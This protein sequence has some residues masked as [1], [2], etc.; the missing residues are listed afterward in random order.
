MSLF[1]DLR[2]A[3]RTFVRNPGFT[4]A[5]VVVLALGIGANTAIFSVVRSVLLEQL[6]VAEPERLCKI[7]ISKPEGRIEAAPVSL[8]DFQEWRRELDS[9]QTL[10]A[11]PAFSFHG[12]TLAGAGP[13]EELNTA[14]VSGGYFEAMGVRPLL[15]RLFT[16]EDDQPPAAARKVALSHAFWRQRFGGDP[17][18]VGRTLRLDG[19]P[20][21]VAAILPPEF[22]LPRPGVQV[23]APLLTISP[24]RIPHHIRD[25]RWLE[26]V[27]RLEPGVTARQAGA[28]LDS[29]LAR[30]ADDF[31]ETNQGWNRS[32]IRPLRA[33]IVQDARRP[34]WALFAAVALVLLIACS[35]VAGLLLARYQQREREM[36]VRATLGAGR[37][38]LLRQ[39]L[40]EGLLLALA[41]GGLGIVL[42]LWC[43]DLLKS[44]PALAIPRAHE[45][46][47]DGSVLLFT[48][49]ASLATLVLFG[50]L[51]AWRS[52]RVDPGSSLRAAPRAGGGA[53]SSRLRSGL[54]V[55][56]MA[57]AV[58]L[59]T[60][61]GLMLHSLWRLSAVEPGFSPERVLA[62]KLTIPTWKY[63]DRA[64]Y[65][66][67]HERFLEAFRSLPGVEA[68][69]AVKTLPF[70]EPP[71]SIE[72]SLPGEGDEPVG[73]RLHPV[74][75]GLLEALDIPLL[76]GRTLTDADG[77]DA[78]VPV[79][80]S[81][82]LAEHFWNRPDVL[83]EQLQA[84]ETPLR[85]VGVAADVH[86]SDLSAE[87]EAAVYL[88]LR[89]SPRRRFAYLLRTPGDPGD[90]A[91]A[92]RQA[93]ARIEP[94][95]PLA[96]LAPLES[97]VEG[98][99][100]RPRALAALLGLFSGLGLLLAAVGLYGL[101]AFLVSRRSYEIGVRMALGACRSDVF[102]LVLGQGARLAAAGLLVGAVASLYFNQRL[103]DLLFG[104]AP[105]DPLSYLSMALVLAAAALAASWFPARRAARISPAR[106]LRGD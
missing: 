26:V 7:W 42:A 96:L 91:G 75:G 50:S 79:V 11:Y 81:R 103:A 20:W 1:S 36:A 77:Y 34:L 39:L 105:A 80:I 17:G 46:G 102:W 97:V 13:A 66:A 47:L 45:I 9:F 99:L 41:A 98:P 100:G 33:E 21:E 55:A 18:L 69:G 57:L 52:S 25:V 8:P 51:P 72:L 87:P 6:P 78:S 88:P 4:A 48:L 31:P 63:P 82:R 3:V 65:L 32:V 70:D 73:A 74:T 60:G 29:L 49:G 90:L 35:N 22:R 40:T 19:E 104:V 38:R 93:V 28:E 86:Y 68:A 64:G 23:W 27:G 62:V 2:F 53:S 16:L 95:Q 59:V 14:Y 56:E 92:V 24:S 101:L 54:V 89:H 12:L 5:A 84:G 76:E 106:A 58:V 43:V 71:E 37:W 44:S 85:V 94:D 83:D 10:G 61:A 30:L 67:L 15:G